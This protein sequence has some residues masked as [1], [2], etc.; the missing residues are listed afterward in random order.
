MTRQQAA[1][2]DFLRAQIGATG[3]C[4]S[5]DEIKDHLGLATKSC[6]NRLV[7]QLEERRLIRR[8]PGRARSI[9]VIDLRLPRPPI[10]DLSPEAIAGQ[11]IARA[12]AKR[13]MNQGQYFGM[14]ELRPI[15]VDVLNNLRRSGL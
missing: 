14:E 12:Q 2:L 8:M 11:I 6:V 5:Y 13:G 9:E 10:T 3:V 7:K 4:P 15:I 1:T